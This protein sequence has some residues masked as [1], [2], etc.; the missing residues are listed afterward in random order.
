MFFSIIM[1]SYNYG[2]C[3][4]EAIES[5]MMQTFPEW[6]LIV[7]DDGSGDDSRQRIAQYAAKDS[8]IRLYTHAD[9]GNHGLPATLQFALNFCR[10]NYIAFL[11]ADDLWTA[12]HL[13]KLNAVLTEYPAV[14][15]I[16]NGVELFGDPQAMKRYDGFF[17]LRQRVW[18]KRHFPC[19]IFHCLLLENFIPT[20]SSVAIERNA[21]LACSF[22]YSY[23]P[24]IDRSLYLQ[25]CRKS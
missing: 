25:L 3:I 7:V 1:A 11:E 10:G 8:R 15:I 14:G 17:A 5:V 13:A 4:G 20:F 23:R 22:S 9:G 2:N 16:A 21:L 6:E 19:N 18:Q 24:W 12:D